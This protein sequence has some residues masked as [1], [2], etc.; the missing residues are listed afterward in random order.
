MEERETRGISRPKCPICGHPDAAQLHD[1]PTKHNWQCSSFKCLHQFQTDRKVSISAIVAEEKRRLAMNAE[2]VAAM[3]T[4]EKSD[5][6]CPTCGKVFKFP[7]WLKNHSCKTKGDGSVEENPD[8]PMP[9]PRKKAKQPKPAAPAPAATGGTMIPVVTEVPEDLV[10]T[11]YG[12]TISILLERREQL[13]KELASVSD[14]VTTV[15]N[16][17][18]T[19]PASPSSALRKVD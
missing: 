8:L 5:R 1:G 3:A 2:E 18:R 9:R 4:D 7:S 19:A 12:V 11:H 17:S 14:A 13:R 16:L 6:T 10:G 15:I